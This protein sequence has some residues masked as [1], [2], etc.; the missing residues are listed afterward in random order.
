V[1]RCGFVLDSSFLEQARLAASRALGDL[2]KLTAQITEEVFRTP[3][4]K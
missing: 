4:A 1:D 2:E 3:A